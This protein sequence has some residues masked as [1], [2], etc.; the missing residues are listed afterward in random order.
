MNDMAA[1]L[2]R[3]CPLCGL[4][5]PARPDV[6]TRP[7]AEVLAFDDLVPQWKGLFRAGRRVF[8]SYGRCGA[9]GLLYTPTFFTEAQLASLYSQMPPNMG[10]VPTEALRRTQRGY[11]EVLK[12]NARLEGG[13]IEVGPDTGLFTENCVREGGFDTFWLFEPNRDALPSLEKVLGDV[14]FHVSHDMANFDHV[15]DQSAGV[16]V[17]IQVLDHLLKPVEALRALRSKIRPGGKIVIVTH[18][19]SSLLRQVFGRR[20]P[21][22]CL[23]HPQIYNPRSMKALV[24]AAGYEMILVQR[25]INYFPVDFLIKHLLWACGIRLTHLT[26]FEGASM[27]LKLGNMITLATPR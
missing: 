11:F 9:C 6:V 4:S 19:E 21:A 26:R 22:F 25:T 5:A 10:I 24:E 13:Y 23:Q 2:R 1:F 27:G 20:W 12:A 18:N 15:P 16:V 7:A 3:D 17:M 14:R 8:F